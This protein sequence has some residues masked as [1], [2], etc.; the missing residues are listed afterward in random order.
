ML[1]K[2]IYIL[3]QKTYILFKK[4]YILF[5]K[6]MFFG[7]YIFAEKHIF[8]VRPLLVHRRQVGICFLAVL[9]IE[10]IIKCSFYI[11]YNVIYSD[12]T[13]M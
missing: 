4:I 13:D 12:A 2:K 9:N 10:T 8:F 1:F 5:Q 3:F 6:H 7:T 11:K